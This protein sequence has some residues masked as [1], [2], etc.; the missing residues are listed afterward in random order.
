MCMQSWSGTKVSEQDIRS[1][2]GPYWYSDRDCSCSVRQD[3]RS[4]TGRSK[5]CYSEQSHSGTPYTGTALC[6]SSRYL[7]QCT[8]EQQVIIHLCSAG[9]QRT[10]PAAKCNGTPQS[11]RTRIRPYIKGGTYHCRPWGCG[12]DTALPFGWSHQLSQSGQRKLGG[13]KAL[14]S[15]SIKSHKEKVFVSYKILF[16]QDRI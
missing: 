9:W 10:F 1:V 4:A 16:S 14:D 7:L 15:K 12:T 8:D 11:F 2:A 6:R 13:I 5:Q 3:I